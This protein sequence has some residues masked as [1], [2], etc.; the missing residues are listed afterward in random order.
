MKQIRYEGHKTTRISRR[1]TK[2]SHD[3]D[4]A[5]GICVSGISRYM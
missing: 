4:F 1:R 3:G 2:F 5:L